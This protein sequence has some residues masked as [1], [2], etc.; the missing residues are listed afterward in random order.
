MIKDAAPTRSI[1]IAKIL[2]LDVLTTAKAVIS[3][4]CNVE[5]S[6][7]A[8]RPN[9]PISLTAVGFE[10][11][12]VSFLQQSP[13]SKARPH[14][15][16]SVT[17]ATFARLVLMSA[18]ARIKEKQHWSCRRHFRKNRCANLRDCHHVWKSRCCNSESIVAFGKLQLLILGC[19]LFSPRR[20][21]ACYDLAPPVATAAEAPV[22]ILARKKRRN[23]GKITNNRTAITIPLY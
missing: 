12:M 3:R 17:F 21:Y 23:A 13:I 20:H 22:T 5:T 15:A 16:I 18:A 11:P 19:P 7:S 14:V 9:V 2:R 4:N 1:I 10:S 8:W 6:V